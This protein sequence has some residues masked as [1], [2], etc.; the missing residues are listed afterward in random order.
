M[1]NQGNQADAMTVSLR[2]LYVWSSNK[3][4]RGWMRADVKGSPSYKSDL[5]INGFAT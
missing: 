4:P 3:K 2:P 1:P 5:V